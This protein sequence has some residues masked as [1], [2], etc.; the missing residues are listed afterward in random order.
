MK[1]LGLLLPHL[2]LDDDARQ[3]VHKEEHLIIVRHVVDGCQLLQEEVA[4]GGHRTALPQLEEALSSH[5]CSLHG[6]IALVEARDECLPIL[7]DSTG[8]VLS[9][10]PF[11]CRPLEEESRMA[12]LGGV[13]RELRG[14][15]KFEHLV[16]AHQP[17]IDLV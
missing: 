7:I 16:E 10:P 6:A 2:V 1:G 15:V 17:V 3:S 11:E 13:I 9:P 12:D 4:V 5:R 14:S 8:L